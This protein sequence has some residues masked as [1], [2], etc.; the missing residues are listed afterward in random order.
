MAPI[1]IIPLPITKTQPL[2]PDSFPRYLIT[3]W[4]LRKRLK[5]KMKNY[6]QSRF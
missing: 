2:S 6:S 4:G 3:R 5:R 1:E